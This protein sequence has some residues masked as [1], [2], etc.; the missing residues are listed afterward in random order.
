MYRP[1]KV[2]VAD[3]HAIVREG[4][5]ALLDD[6]PDIEVIGQ[7][8]SGREAIHLIRAQ[9]PNVVVMDI[10]MPDMTGLEAASLCQSEFS[11]V[12][13][14]I[15]TIHEEEAFFFEALHAGAVGYVLKEAPGS[16]LLSAVRA[17]YEGNVYLSPKLA[18]DLVKAYLDRQP[19][20]PSPD[21][22]LTPRE[23]EI[24]T[25]LVR[26]LTNR[27]MAAQL[28]LSINTIKTH[29]LRIYQKLHLDGAR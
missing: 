3:D 2:A 21:S 25:L 26:G 8:G 10:T 19:R 11:E 1:I 27:E 16:E 12:N 4:L 17:V 14:V 29:R 9:R 18:G 22:P 5:V 7:A 28:T 15:L 13:I 20:R 6:E 24:L 23:R